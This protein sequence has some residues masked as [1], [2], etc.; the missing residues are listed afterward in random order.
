MSCVVWV[1]I[2]TNGSRRSRYATVDNQTPYLEIVST[3]NQGQINPE[4]HQWIELCVRDDIVL[5]FFFSSSLTARKSSG[6]RE[7][8]T[9]R[10]CG[11]FGTKFIDKG[12]K[13]SIFEALALALGCAS[14]NAHRWWRFGAR[15]HSGWSCNSQNEVI[16]L[17]LGRPNS[18]TPSY[19][20]LCILVFVCLFV[21]HIYL[22]IHPSITQPINQQTKIAL[23]RI[24][25]NKPNTT[26]SPTQPNLPS[27]PFS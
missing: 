4:R 2:D 19:M 21:S 12:P 1:D 20:Y 10:P 16:H 13:C 22:F 24:T 11:R 27:L 17:S 3:S 15:P 26:K 8:G 23:A 25:L 5:S 18:C 9:M 14:S 7:R 6:W